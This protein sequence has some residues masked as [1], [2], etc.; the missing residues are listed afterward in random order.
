M[1]SSMFPGVKV[2]VSSFAERLGLR[3]VA[4]RFSVAPVCGIGELSK[5]S[6]ATSE[7][8]AGRFVLRTQ[9]RGSAPHVPAL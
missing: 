1:S 4:M 6:V 8:W 5:S 9:S 3:E 7:W 2:G